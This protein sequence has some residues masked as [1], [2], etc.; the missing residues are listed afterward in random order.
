MPAD[1]ELRMKDGSRLTAEILYFRPDHPTLLQSFSSHTIDV[2]PRFPRLS[3][4]LEHWRR[5]VGAMIHSI[6]IAHSDWV[7][8]TVFRN[9]DNLLRLN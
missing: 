2:A 9:V 7:G 4:F 6:L 5:E 1:F 8:P 3:A